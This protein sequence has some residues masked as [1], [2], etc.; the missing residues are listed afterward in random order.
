MCRQKLQL[1]RLT[2]GVRCVHVQRFRSNL[3]PNSCLNS[4]LKRPRRN[5]RLLCNLNRSRSWQPVT[6]SWNAIWQ[7]AIVWAQTKVTLNL[8]KKH[9]LSSISLTPSQNPQIPFFCCCCNS[10]SWLKVDTFSLYCPNVSR[11][12]ATL[13][14]FFLKWTM[15]YGI[16]NVHRAVNMTTATMHCSFQTIRN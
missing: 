4:D 9:I 14:C 16:C 2:A 13:S 6:I 12:I 10:T 1:W 7:F 15:G 3:S 11:N 8:A 5:T